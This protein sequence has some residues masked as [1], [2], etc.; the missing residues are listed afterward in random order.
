MPPAF[1]L[2]D[3]R[4][5]SGEVRDVSSPLSAILIA[6]HN[7]DWFGGLVGN[8]DVCA[9]WEQHAGSV[10]DLR[11]YRNGASGHVD[12]AC[13][14]VDVGATELQAVLNRADSQRSTFDS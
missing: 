6:N 5:K 8:D 13:V 2:L 9:E 12:Y 3:V 11:N 4:G 10:F 7:L 14:G 1:A